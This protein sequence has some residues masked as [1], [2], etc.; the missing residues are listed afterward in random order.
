[1]RHQRSHLLLCNRIDT[2][3]P[4]LLDTCS[5]GDTGWADEVSL[6]PEDCRYWPLR[7]RYLVGACPSY[8]P[9][10]DSNTRSRVCMAS[11]FVVYESVTY[12]PKTDEMPLDMAMNMIW[13]VVEGNLAIVSGKLTS[14]FLRFEA[15]TT[16]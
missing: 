11:I 7:V 16:Y 14:N 8:L 13:A 12:N 2:R 15:R 6:W 4:R 3:R 1:M 5:T 9:H 10:C